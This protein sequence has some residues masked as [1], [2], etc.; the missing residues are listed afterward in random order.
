MRVSRSDEVMNPL[1]FLQTPKHSFY[2]DLESDYINKQRSKA[3]L[4]SRR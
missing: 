1:L 3:S 2:T 4:D